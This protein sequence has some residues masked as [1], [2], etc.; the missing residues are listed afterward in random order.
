MPHVLFVFG[1]RPEVIKLAPV[2]HTLR[3][4]PQAPRI[5]LCSTGQHR[6]MLDS[7]LAAFA[8]RADLDLQVMQPGQQPADV[9]GRLVLAL[10]PLLSDLQPDVVV[11]QGD[12]TTVMAAA[13]VGFL[14]GVRVAHVEAGLR[15]RNRHAPFPEE[16][17]RRVAG[18]VADCHFAPTPQAQANLLAEG[19]APESVYLT[20]N[21]I[22]DALA[23]MR[24]RLPSLPP[25]ALKPTS[26]HRLVLVTAHRRESFGTPLR[27]LCHALREIAEL[28]PDVELI[29]PVHLNPQVH[30]PVHELLAQAPRVRLVAPLP[31]T[32]FVALLLQAHLL[33]TDSGGIQEEAPGLGKPV[34]VLRDVTERPEA[35]SAGVVKLV[36][37]DRQRIV[38]AATALLSNPTEYARMARPVHVYG[39]GRASQ[40]I[41]EILTTGQM[42]SAPFTPE[43]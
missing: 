25:P 21:T 36:G 37:T 22:V 43:A 15:T 7:A 11:V 26:G 5:T 13:L 41:V 32:E 42:Q 24:E 23:W 1:T 16:I 20:G 9:L 17:N 8:L 33:I 39:D 40:R 6:D 3:A 12:T 4:L 35:V 14:A 19:V 34:L 10:R 38:T 2:I 18:V 27:N 29:Y 28:C 31:Y 30:A